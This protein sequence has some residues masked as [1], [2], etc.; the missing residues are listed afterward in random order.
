MLKISPVLDLNILIVHLVISVFALCLC[1]LSFVAVLRSKKTPY[2]TKLLSLGLLIY[3]SL[4]IAS[5]IGRKFFSHE[6][7]VV[8]RQL[9]HGFQMA[10]LS[11]IVSMAFERLFVLNWPYVFLR[12][13]TRGRIRKVCIAIIVFSFLQF[14]LYQGIVCYSRG[15][16]VGCGAEMSIYYLMMSIVFSICAIAS[17]VKI[18][19]IIRNRSVGMI[20]L[21]QY[22]GT[23][24]SLAYLI[25]CAISAVAFVG[26][27]IYFAFSVAN[28]TIVM[29]HVANITDAVYLFNCIGDPLVYVVWFK[30]VRMEI[31]NMCSKIC[32]CL[33]PS[34]EKMRKEVFDIHCYEQTNASDK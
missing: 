5:A 6:E 29:G 17:Y 26:I 20:S 10:A 34:V 9:S 1:S 27:S 28:G 30:E 19:R 22:K 15:K 4:F 18:F 33:E 24:A 2:P 16:I 11:I 7:G 23:G 31:L 12:V 13:G 14:I 21:K 32:H 8:F 3:D 25:N